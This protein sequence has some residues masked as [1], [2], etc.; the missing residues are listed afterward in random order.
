MAVFYFRRSHW[1]RIFIR[2]TCLPPSVNDLER[3]FAFVPVHLF[4]YLPI[5]FD[6][7]VI[8][9]ALLVDITLPARKD[10]GIAGYD[11]PDLIFCKLFIK[12]SEPGSGR[13]VFF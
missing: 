9:D 5:R 11:Q 6:K 7:T 4:G 12:V 1:D 8:I 13:S 3:N 10:I 2:N